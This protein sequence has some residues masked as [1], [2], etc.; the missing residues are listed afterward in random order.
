MLFYY[1]LKLIPLA[2]LLLIFSLLNFLLAISSGYKQPGTYVCLQ[3]QP[4]YSMLNV[5]VVLI[6][7]FSFLHIDTDASS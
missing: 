7:A 6:F 2:L 3:S 4:V 5:L 1:M